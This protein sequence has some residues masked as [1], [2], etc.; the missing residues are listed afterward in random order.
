MRGPPTGA[1]IRRLHTFDEAGDV[2]RGGGRHAFP[3]SS[4]EDLARKRK[5]RLSPDAHHRRRRSRSNEHRRRRLNRSR[6][7]ERA[8]IRRGRNGEHSKGASGT[9]EGNLGD[10]STGMQ[11]K[12][13]QNGSICA[14]EIMADIQH[15]TSKVKAAGKCLTFRDALK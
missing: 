10:C 3:Q 12:D 6:S 1:L 8:S 2:R 13:H 14:A 9:R 15:Y 7:R 4:G 5:R 11:S